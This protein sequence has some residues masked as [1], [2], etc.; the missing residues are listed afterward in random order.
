M[1]HAG[2]AAPVFGLHR[3]DKTAVALGDDAVLQGLGIAGGDLG[4]NIPHLG[5]GGA[6]LAAD[7]IEL[8][9]GV[10]GDLLLRHDGG[11]DLFFQIFV[12]GEEG[13]V[14]VQGGLLPLTLV[15]VVL[16]Q[17]GGAQHGAD[18]EQLR[19]VEKAPLVGPLQRAGD[20]LDA[21]KARAALEPDELGGVLGLL[22]PFFTLA[23]M[24]AGAQ[25]PAGLLGGLGGGFGRQKLQD[26]R[27]LDGGKGFFL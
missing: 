8:R 5:G 21:R 13:E 18:G 14:P 4:Q 7:L 23:E 10:V 27:Q 20:I 9:A 3:H 16:S 2:E 24:G 26:F 1:D 6:D 22:L 15:P 17:A 19:G 25:G 12:P 11:L